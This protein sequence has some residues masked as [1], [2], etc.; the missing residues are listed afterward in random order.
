VARKGW[1]N[2]DVCFVSALHTELDFYSTH[3]LKRVAPTRHL[4]CAPTSFLVQILI[5]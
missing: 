3:S 1:H 5:L 4:C 2:D